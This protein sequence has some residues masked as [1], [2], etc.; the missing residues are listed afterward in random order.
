MV[1]RDQSTFRGTPDPH[2][3]NRNDLAMMEAVM[4]RLGINEGRLLALLQ[5]L[6]QQ[7]MPRFIE[8][9]GMAF[10]S[11]PETIRERLGPG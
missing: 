8:S 4:N 9:R 7:D 5:E 3:F 6:M 2:P 10:D 11:L 1:N